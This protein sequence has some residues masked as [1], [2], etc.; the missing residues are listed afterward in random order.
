MTRISL[1]EYSS[2]INLSELNNSSTDVCDDELGELILKSGERISKSLKLSS[3][4]FIIKDQTL[5]VTGVAGIVRV[6]PDF[7]LEVAPKFLGLDSVN[8][9]WREDFF[10]LATL[11]KHGRLLN[12]DH[13][14]AATG[15]RGDLHTL[16]A[17]TVADM[18]W[19]NYRRPLRTYTNKTFTS[20]A[21][22]GEIDPESFIQPS[23]EGFEQSGITYSR[24]NDYNAVLLA[25]AKQLLSQ[26]R[27]PGTISQLERMVY[28]LSPQ[29]QRKSFVRNRRLPNRSVRWQP[30]LELSMDVLNGF[31]LT[32]DP[33][34]LWAPGYVLDTWRVW[35]DF[36]KVSMRLSFGSD[37]VQSQVSSLLGTKEKFSNGT[38]I[39]K[40][41][42]RVRPDL[43]IND[44]QSNKPYFI[45]DAKYKGNIKNERISISEQDLYE[46][47][48]FSKATGCKNVL[49][50]YPALSSIQT[51][52]GEVKVFER[53]TIGDIT[54]I[55]VEIETK[56]ISLIGGLSRFS[57]QCA[58]DLQ[59]ILVKW[60]T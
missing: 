6:N 27:D 39:G 2:P 47:L 25:A 7:E 5:R 60:G 53:Q 48:A 49:L 35:Q 34:K 30:L 15:E 3:N 51:Q 56:G 10:F 38:L 45:L 28:S 44:V 8:S 24:E 29:R 42:S 55:G 14:R 1:I 54:I 40:V 33:G 59:D 13:L 58:T 20:F 18:Y 37:Q 31:G 23:P 22:D 16:V 46:S 52:L 41:H 17:R 26:I 57:R 32:L 19:N 9:R 21:I 4:P 43:I 36:L 11:S 50:A 12:N